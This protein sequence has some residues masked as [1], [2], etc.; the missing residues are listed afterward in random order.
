MWTKS[1]KIHIVISVSCSLACMACLPIYM[2][3]QND[4]K[5]PVFPFMTSY[6]T[7]IILENQYICCGMPPGLLDIIKF[8][9]AL[10]LVDCLY[11]TLF[12]KNHYDSIHKVNAY[13]ISITLLYFS[14]YDF[15]K[16]HF[17][18]L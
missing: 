11:C 7:S 15:C 2:Y 3:S 8:H 1:P 18:T 12:Y 16:S 10:Y 14:L 9:S 6:Q 5:C 4:A 17:M 13:F